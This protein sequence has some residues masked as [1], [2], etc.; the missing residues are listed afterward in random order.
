MRTA[1]I[2]LA[3][4]PNRTAVCTIDWTSESA[5]VRLLHDRS[6]M[7]LID[8]CRTADKTGI[9][10]PFGWPQPF[11][12][13]VRAHADRR[14]WPGRHEPPDA[15]RA[16]LALRETDREVRRRTQRAP[17]SVAA[18]R[19]GLT[20]VRCALLQDELGDVD[21]T[22]LTGSVAEVYPAASLCTWGLRWTGY[23]GAA[24]RDRLPAMVAELARLAPGLQFA[25][26][27]RDELEA[28]DDAFDALVC[29]LTA[30]AVADGRTHRP[31]PEQAHLAVA[32]G[33]IHVP[34]DDR[35]AVGAGD[36]AG[37]PS[38]GGPRRSCT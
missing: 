25:D 34:S 31:S 15:F 7:A 4:K 36:L 27:V 38:P 1:G 2:D 9:D 28:D 24:G 6:D 32:E 12:A 8:V 11:V 33:W 3:T 23:K 14:P 22:G 18:D 13:A 17:L 30:R 16:H 19:I 21:R 20:A 37:A 10:C 29:A 35:P 5:T 26:G